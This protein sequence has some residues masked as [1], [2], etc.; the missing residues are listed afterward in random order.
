MEIMDMLFNTFFKIFI[1]L[2]I[3]PNNPKC[4]FRKEY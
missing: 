4:P 2:L 3:A 1:D